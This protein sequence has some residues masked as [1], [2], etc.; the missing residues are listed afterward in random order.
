[1]T[2][3]SIT[4][5]NKNVIPDGPLIVGGGWGRQSPPFAPP[6]RL[7]SFYRVTRDLRRRWRHENVVVKSTRTLRSSHLYPGSFSDPSSP[8][9]TTPRTTKRSIL[10]RS[11]RSWLTFACQERRLRHGVF[12]TVLRRNGPRET[13]LK[14]RTRE[15][16]VVSDPWI[17]ANRIA[18]LHVVCSMKY[19]RRYRAR[20]GDVNPDVGVTLLSSRT[21]AYWFIRRINQTLVGFGPNSLDRRPVRTC[22]FGRVCCTRWTCCCYYYY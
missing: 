13:L 8:W 22:V 18:Y 9:R 21:S 2:N 12:E 20:R 1:M 6:R 15:L 17:T 3:V 5:A 14:L 16:I 19:T 11:W 10:A 7:R 4:D